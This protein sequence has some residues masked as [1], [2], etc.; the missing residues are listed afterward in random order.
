VEEMLAA[1]DQQKK[2]N[3]QLSEEKKKRD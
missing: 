3:E 2:W 1:K